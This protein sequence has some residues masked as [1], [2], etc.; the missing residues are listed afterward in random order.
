MKGGVAK[1]TLCKEIAYFLSITKLYRILI[2]DVDPQCNITQSFLQKYD[3][4][5]TDKTLTEKPTLKSIESIFTANK[6]IEGENKE[7]IVKLSDNLDLLPGDMDIGFVKRSAQVAKDE[8]RL[9]LYINKNNLKDDYDF[10]FI[11]CPPTYSYHSVVA[12]SASDYYYV[13][14]KPDVYSVLG[15]DL[16]L[17]VIEDLQ[18]DNPAFSDRKLKCLG[19]IY[20]LVR[21][22]GMKTKI[23]SIDRFLDKKGIFKF[24]TC[25][26]HYDRVANG[27][28]KLFIPDRAYEPVK[29]NLSK[30]CDEFIGRINDADKSTN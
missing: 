10:I 16:L 25:F 19:V 24:N 28:V 2:I 29:N 26:R 4:I 11:D 21:I 12:L 13:P 23:N 9:L 30:I 18:D 5:K 22:P 27:R 1:T 6:I 20:S 7:C 3:Y 17:K 14:V 15:L 8:Q